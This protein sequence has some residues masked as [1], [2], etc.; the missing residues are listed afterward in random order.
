M[1]LSLPTFIP[2][3]SPVPALDP[4]E[5]D[6]ETDEEEPAL[7]TPSRRSRRV[8]VSSTYE[9][10]DIFVVNKGGKRRKDIREQE[11]GNVEV[12]AP[13]PAPRA[14]ESR[15]VKE[16]TSNDTNA[17]VA[18]LTGIINSLKR[19]LREQ[20]DILSNSDSLLS[21][22]ETEIRYLRAQ[23]ASKDKEILSNEKTI[24]R[25]RITLDDRTKE[26]N[27][28]DDDLDREQV[29]HAQTA[30]RLA[31][32]EKRRKEDNERSTGQSQRAMQEIA[33]LNDLL[34]MERQA[35]ETRGRED[36]ARV[37]RESDRTMQELAML[38]ELVVSER[39]AHERRVRE[40]EMRS[41]PQTQTVSR[42]EDLRNFDVNE[43]FLENP[44]IANT[45]LY[46]HQPAPASASFALQFQVQR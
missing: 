31:A 11:D 21:S 10:H 19:S 24:T 4:D 26:A 45:S 43:H 34:V 32:S 44:S 5:S 8:P 25:L 23:L 22:K 9:T 37:A 39:Q 6:T 42:L 20:S 3:L 1:K 17:Q 15:R 35:F 12:V 13:L 33:R 16:Q 27:G 30:A 46:R 18:Y 2:Y 7:I 40:L 14:Y 41:H 29:A 36:N 28:L 38:N